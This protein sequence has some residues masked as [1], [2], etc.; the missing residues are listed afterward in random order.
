MSL[1]VFTKN[2]IIPGSILELYLIE[3]WKLFQNPAI[4]F[5]SFFKSLLFCSFI[6]FKGTPE[7]SIPSNYIYFMKTTNGFL[8]I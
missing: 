6:I 5:L 1:T 2:W 4:L 3:M 7:T 8:E